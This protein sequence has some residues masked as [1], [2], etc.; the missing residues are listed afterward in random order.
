MSN[1]SPWKDN[2]IRAALIGCLGTIAAAIIGGLCILLAV[3]LERQ[4]T[5]VP[6]T[7]PVTFTAEVTDTP[8]I[9][10]TPTQFVTETFTPT[11]TPTATPTPPGTVLFEEGFEDGGG[12]PFRQGTEGVGTSGVVFDNGN[13]VFEVNNLDAD[14]S[15]ETS[16]PLRDLFRNGTIE[17]RFKYLN[18]IN[19]SDEDN[20]SFDFHFRLQQSN[21]EESY[22]LSIRPSSK[23]VELYYVN[24]QGTWDSSPITWFLFP[25]EVDKWFSVRI[26]VTD[27]EIRVFVDQNLT[28]ETQPLFVAPNTKIVGAGEVDLYLRNNLH[29]RL[30]D[31]RVIELP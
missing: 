10:L 27:P 17:F 30:D 5:P 18:L 26:E 29:I 4:P 3:S 25:F 13:Y 6:D 14:A 31:F 23:T 11:F 20:G 9:T 2:T 12:F 8:S 1:N 15:T 22:V 24:A 28:S 16:I 21:D 19:S 7:T